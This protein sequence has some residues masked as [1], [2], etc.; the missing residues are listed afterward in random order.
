[1]AL[2]ERVTQDLTAA[3]KARDALKTSVLRLAKAAFKNREIEKRGPLDEGEAVRVLQGLVKQCED[4]AEQ[5][6]KGGRPEL[7]EKELAEV[8]VLKAYLPQDASEAEIDAAVTAALEETGATSPKDMGRVM[9]ATLASL[10][11]SGRGV[12]GKKVSDVVRS[13]LSGSGA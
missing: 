6:R 10:G 3:M 12:D 13:R 11:L 4:A 9:K 5:F 1:M 7:A 2:P 8:E